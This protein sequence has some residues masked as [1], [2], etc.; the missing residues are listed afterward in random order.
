MICPEC[1]AQLSAELTCQDHFYQMLYWENED[2][3]N[4]EVHHLMVLCYYLQHPSL[5]TPEG[6]QMG[7]QLLKEFVGDGV[8]PQEMRRK[9]RDVVDSGNRTIKIA[10][11]APGSYDSPI[12]WTMRAADV[13]AGGIEHYIENVYQWA[14]LT[15]ESLRNV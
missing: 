13:V 4:G 9:I 6:L 15:H 12:T 10:H 7:R 11:G 8:T 14:R 3:K 1:G 5:Y 2:P